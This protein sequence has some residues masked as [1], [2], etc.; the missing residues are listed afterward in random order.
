LS[1]SYLLWSCPLYRAT[2]AWWVVLL[3]G[4]FLLQFTVFVSPNF[5]EDISLAPC[6]CCTMRLFSAGGSQLPQG[7][8]ISLAQFLWLSASPCS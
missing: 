1:W 2:F 3:S 7:S 5:P 8:T 6:Y 4:Q